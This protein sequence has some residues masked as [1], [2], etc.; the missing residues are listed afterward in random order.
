M[1]SAARMHI[2]QSS[3]FLSSSLNA[4]ASPQ[5]RPNWLDTICALHTRDRWQACVMCAKWSLTCTANRKAQEKCC[6]RLPLLHDSGLSSNRRYEKSPPTYFERGCCHGTLNVALVQR[7]D[8]DDVV[9]V[10]LQ[11]G[12]SVRFGVAGEVHSLHYIAFFGVIKTQTIERCVNTNKAQGGCPAA[13]LSTD[14][15]SVCSP[16]HRGRLS[17]AHAR[18]PL[19]PS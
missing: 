9:C 17:I 7:E 3:G 19:T 15:R 14:H 13:D 10:G 12:Q 18:C 6:R 11:A 4:V 8:S 1:K 16:S 2:S 5:Y